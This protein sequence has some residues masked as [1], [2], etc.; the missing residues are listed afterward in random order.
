[1]GTLYDLSFWSRV[2]D[3]VNA[4]M[5][6]CSAFIFFPTFSFKGHIETEGFGL[7]ARDMGYICWGLP[8]SEENGNILTYTLD[9]RICF[10]SGSPIF[11]K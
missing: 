4:G 2:F 6:S 3:V 8:N 10:G 5:G 1:M 7:M 11:L 9:I